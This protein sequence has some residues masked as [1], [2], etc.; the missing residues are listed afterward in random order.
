MSV[1]SP[2]CANDGPT[3]LVFVAET[4]VGKMTTKRVYVQKRYLKCFNKFQS[5]AWLVEP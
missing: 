5:V 4:Y 2:H 1:N 3:P